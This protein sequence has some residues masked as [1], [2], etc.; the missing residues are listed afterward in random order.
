ME[1]K[2]IVV[3]ANTPYPEITGATRD[4]KT[5]GILKNLMS[6]QDGEL[7]GVLQYFYQSSVGNN[8][9]SE[10][11]NILEEISIVEMMHM[12]QLSHAIVDFG[13]DPKYDNSQGQF[14]NTGVVNYTQKLRE[15]LEQNIRL[16]EG[17][18]RNYNNA[19]NMVENQSLKNLF[20][21]I[22]EDEKL[23]MQVFTHLMNTV[24]FMS[25]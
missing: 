24:K 23:H 22:I 9:Q 18:I 12:E 4:M 3:R 11:A 8:I 20:R 16:E 7:R 15:A 5:V 14:F 1:L 17:A 21:R 25:L 10:I 6:S 2:E 13:G 19:I